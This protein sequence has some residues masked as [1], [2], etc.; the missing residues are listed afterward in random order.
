MTKIANY[1]SS[2]EMIKVCNIFGIVLLLVNVVIV[3]YFVLPM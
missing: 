3:R 2:K 1:F